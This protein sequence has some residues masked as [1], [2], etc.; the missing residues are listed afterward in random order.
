MPRE[1]G[2]VLSPEMKVYGTTGLR[3][4]DISHWPKEL[5]GPPMASIYAAGEKAA[6]IIKGEHGWL[7]N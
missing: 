2:G 6:D 4:I 1:L 7:G 5:S 3:V